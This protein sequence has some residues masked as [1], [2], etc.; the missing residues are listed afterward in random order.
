MC[1]EM[2]PSWCRQ[3]NWGNRGIPWVNC[4]V[5]CVWKTTGKDSS[6]VCAIAW[7]NGANYSVF[8][9]GMTSHSKISQFNWECIGR[10]RKNCHLGIQFMEQIMRHLLSSALRWSVILRHVMRQGDGAVDMGIQAYRRCKPSVIGPLLLEQRDFKLLSTAVLNKKACVVIII[11]EKDQQ[12]EPLS[13][14][15]INSNEII[16]YIKSFIYPNECTIRM[17]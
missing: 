10:Y 16:L 5:L 2:M 14:Q 3:V 13:L 1:L 8:P 15:L 11:R 7:Q 17:L 12:D 6:E 4:A 9:S